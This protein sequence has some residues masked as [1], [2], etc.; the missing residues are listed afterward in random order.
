[1]MREITVLTNQHGMSGVSRKRYPP[2]VVVP[3]RRNPVF[4]LV[5]ANIASFRRP[6]DSGLEYPTQRGRIFFDVVKSLLTLEIHGISMPYLDPK[7]SPGGCVIGVV[8]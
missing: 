7:G 1:M 2:S 3:G 5:Y 8:D 4:H 6:I